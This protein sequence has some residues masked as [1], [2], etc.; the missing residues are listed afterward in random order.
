MS[1]DARLLQDLAFDGGMDDFVRLNVPAGDLPGAAAGLD[2]P[3]DEQHP[4]ALHDNAPAADGCLAEVEVTAAVR[5]AGRAI[6]S[7][8][9][10]GRE[11]R[12]TLGAVSGDAHRTALAAVVGSTSLANA[13]RAAIASAP[14]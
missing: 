4:V 12:P 6:A 8:F 1:D 2:A 5:K 11:Q 14:A 10:L 3:L 13:A 7:A 9:E